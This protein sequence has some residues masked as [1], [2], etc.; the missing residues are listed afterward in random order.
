[1]LPFLGMC[2]GNFLRKKFPVCP[3]K[4]IFFALSAQAFS[5]VSQGGFFG[6]K[7]PYSPAKTSSSVSIMS[8]ALTISFI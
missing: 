6:T 1:M 8:M 4:I 7:P 5:V 2:Q 3:S